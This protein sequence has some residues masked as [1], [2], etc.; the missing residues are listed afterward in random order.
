MDKKKL[1]EILLKR[2]D[3]R[4]LLVDDLLKGVINDALDKVVKDTANPF[5]DIAKAATMPAIE[6]ALSEYL[7]KLIADLQAE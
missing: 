4:G 7:D 3:L 1:V 6:K 2:V 5:D